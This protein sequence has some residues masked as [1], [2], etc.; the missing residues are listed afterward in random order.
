MENM[1]IWACKKLHQPQLPH[2]PGQFEN[3]FENIAQPKR[4]ITRI[5]ARM[6]II[7]DSDGG[8]SV[9][10]KTVHST[11]ATEW[12]DCADIK[13]TA[14]TDSGIW[15]VAVPVLAAMHAKPIRVIIH[16]R[17]EDTVHRPIRMNRD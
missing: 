14:A 6:A 2:P 12:L 17:A 5:C 8:Y 4:P 11:A 7:S 13:S 9:V 10:E 3:E 16:G 1:A 15:P